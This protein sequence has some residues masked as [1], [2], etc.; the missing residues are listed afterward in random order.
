MKTEEPITIAWYKRSIWQKL[1][2]LGLILLFI[3]APTSI[4]WILHKLIYGIGIAMFIVGI[5]LL[6]KELGR[7]ESTEV[8]SLD[9]EYKPL[10]KNN[11]LDAS[12]KAAKQSS[13]KTN[14]PQS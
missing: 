10:A 8:Y 5:V 12:E 7:M 11:I 13:P 9:E 6:K 4:A 14:S 2:L 3:V 1:A